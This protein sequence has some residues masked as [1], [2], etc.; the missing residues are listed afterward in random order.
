MLAR[1]ILQK[2]AM[3]TWP[4]GLFRMMQQF[5]TQWGM[6]S[7]GS[8]MVTIPVMTLF[9]ASSKFLVTGLTLGGTKE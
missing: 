3:Y 6:F 7:A 8:L 2:E 4:L 1:V 5:Q 9:M